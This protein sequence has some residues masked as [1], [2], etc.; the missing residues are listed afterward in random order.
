MPMLPYIKTLDSQGQSI[1]YF[2]RDGNNISVVR[3]KMPFCHFFVEVVPNV[4]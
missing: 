2:L 3:V 1:G 4:F